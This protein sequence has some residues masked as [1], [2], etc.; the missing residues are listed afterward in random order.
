MYLNT[1]LRLSPTDSSLLRFVGLFSKLIATPIW[2]VSADRTGEPGMLMAVSVG[3]TALM[4]ELYRRPSVAGSIGCLLLLKVVRS[5]TNGASTL[6]DILT[7]TTIADKPG[8]PTCVIAAAVAA[9]N[10]FGSPL[11][12]SFCPRYGGQRLMGAVAWGFG[13][14]AVGVA[15]D[16]YG[17]SAIFLFTYL[18]AAVVVLLLLVAGPPSKGASSKSLDG[19]GA[20]KPK[21]T[22]SQVMREFATL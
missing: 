21:R 16:R 1:A 17:F 13:S 18:W 5:G 6:L 8:K 22:A 11:S 3:L 14:A 9:L 7:M 15:I 19:R 20:A 4:L 12:P 10:L 2:G